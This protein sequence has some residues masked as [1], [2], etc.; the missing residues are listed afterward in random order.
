MNKS[1]LI[2]A[3]V[4][5]VASGASAQRISEKAVT[6][7][8]APAAQNLR[9][10]PVGHEVAEMATS[11]QRK[12]FAQKAKKAATKVNAFYRR[13]AGVFYY[14]M[15][16]DFNGYI[17]PF[18]QAHPFM[19]NTFVNMSTSSAPSLTYNWQV[20]L[21]DRQAKA[22]QWYT[23]S[24]K[25]IQVTYNYEV[26]SVPMLT[27]KSGSVSDTYAI[28][29]YK[30]NTTTGVATN[31]AQS[32]V[33]AM[34]VNTE[35]FSSL[36]SP[37]LAMSHYAGSSDRRGTSKHGWT[38]YTGCKAPD[39]SDNGCW[40]GRNEYTDS[41]G[42]VNPFNLVAAAFEKPEHPYVLNKVYGRVGN[43]TLKS[44]ANVT[45]TAKVYKLDEVKQYEDSALVGYNTE[46][47]AKLE[48][49]LI[50][51]GTC[52]LNAASLNDE[53][54][55][56]E[57]PLQ[58]EVEGIPM[59][60]A[61]EIDS[62]ILVVIT[63]YNDAAVNS[64]TFT[65]TSDK[66]DEGFGEL[67]YIGRATGTVPTSI[68]GLN[69]FFTSG[70]MKVGMSIM[71]DVETPFIVYN[72]N[73]ETGEVNFPAAGGSKSVEIYSYK[74]SEDWNTTLADGSDIP[75]WLHI[76]YVD[77]TGDSE[78]LVTATVKADAYPAGQKGGRRADVKFGFPGA[79]LTY[80]VRQNDQSGLDE[81]TVSGV[82]AYAANGNFYVN[83]KGAENAGELNIY[84]VAGKLV[85]TAVLSEGTNILDAQDLAKGVYMLQ[86]GNNTVKVVK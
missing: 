83:V 62:P 73:N 34:P 48:D 60:I 42:N 75:D 69:N 81:V 25:D 72:Y 64:L 17:M 1:L 16:K 53:S 33:L 10:L 22:R 77:G 50:A 26:D 39:G 12:A 23:A 54:A 24:S 6:N 68:Y 80:I 52:T 86:F 67:A 9:A 45:L 85:K 31:E 3:A 55:I 46:E 71:L 32:E 43:V 79:H 59:E 28:K 4:A 19:E 37:L 29:G 61:P 18:L 70:Q 13:P 8:V 58:T 5:T 78:G 57:F 63:G 2:A 66:E 20:Q 51:S 84:N 30:M 41:K 47:C 82:Q 38:Y 27:A 74:N 21:Y 36:T 15:N 40:F 76:S 7:Y 49:N 65:I 14:Q 35:A 11:A 56:L 44:G